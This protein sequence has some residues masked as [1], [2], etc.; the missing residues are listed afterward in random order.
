MEVVKNINFAR[1]VQKDEKPII[2]L[3]YA[4]WSI[5]SQEI[6]KDF[7]KWAN[8]YPKYQ[9]VKIDVNKNKRLAKKYKVAGVPTIVLVSEGELVDV[10]MGPQIKETFEYFLK[11]EIDRKWL[12]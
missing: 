6:E 7:S 9:F 5:A 1:D 11:N 2:V 10:F 8:L 3:F 12:K 4:E